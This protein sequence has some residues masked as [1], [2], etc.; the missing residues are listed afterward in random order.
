MCPWMLTVNL[1]IYIYLYVWSDKSEIS[2]KGMTN[3][4]NS[5]NQISEYF[6]Y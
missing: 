6:Q 5:K 3:I 4:Q 1:K 2:N